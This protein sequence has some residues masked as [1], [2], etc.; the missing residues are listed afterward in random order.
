MSASVSIQ[1][2]EA[3]EKVAIDSLTRMMLQTLDK[4]GRNAHNAVADDK[5]QTQFL[6]SEVDRLQR[7]VRSLSV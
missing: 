3:M 7:D 6:W 5:L 2:G 4:L 1:L